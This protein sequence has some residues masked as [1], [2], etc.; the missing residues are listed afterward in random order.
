M[1]IRLDSASAFQ[2]AVISPHYDSLLVKVIAHGKDHPT[3]ASK[4]SRALA[5][6]R[7]RGVKV[8]PGPFGA[9]GCHLPHW[10]GGW[11]GWVGLGGPL[12]LRAVGSKSCLWPQCNYQSRYRSAPVRLK[13]H[14]VQE[15]AVE[16]I[17]SN[18]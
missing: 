5:E 18:C 12:L 4:M 13:W 6:F 7:I 14:K 9:A 11:G 3:A 2:G 8:G 10:G 16:G 17:L 15:G 1:G